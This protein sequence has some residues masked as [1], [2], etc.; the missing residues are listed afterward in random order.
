MDEGTLPSDYQAIMKIVAASAAPVPAKDVS[1]GLGKG[2]Q[3]AQVEPVRGQLKR[4][5]ERG[6][7]HKTPAGRFTTH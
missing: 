4:L 1:V 5:A 3:P 2:V 6:W 7:L